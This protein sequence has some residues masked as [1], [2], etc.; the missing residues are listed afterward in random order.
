MI[1]IIDR[2][3]QFRDN[4]VAE[5]ANPKY[6]RQGEEIFVVG[7]PLG[8]MFSV[9]QGII[10]ALHRNIA[11]DLGVNFIQTDATTNPGNSGGPFFDFNGRVVGICSFGI[12]ANEFLMMPSG[13]NF[14]VEATQIRRFL[15]G[16]I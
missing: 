15:K 3:V 5:I 14:A 9:S 16:I 2:K 11:D 7:C 6:M 10:S 8:M 4:Q 13:L 12:S 1:K